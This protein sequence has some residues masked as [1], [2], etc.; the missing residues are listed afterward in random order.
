MCIA[1]AKNVDTSD[2]DEDAIDCDVCQHTHA[3]DECPHEGECYEECGE[4]GCDTRLGY[5]SCMPEEEFD[6]HPDREPGYDCEGQWFC[7][8]H[9]KA[10]SNS[11]DE[12]SEDE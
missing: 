12:N 1:C 5:K 9:R 11:E 7:P 10:A 3:E 8:A 4:Y 6:E 2:V